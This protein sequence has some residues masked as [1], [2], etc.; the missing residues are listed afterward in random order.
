MIRSASIVLAAL[1]STSALA[2]SPG[3]T[4]GTAAVLDEGQWELGLYAALRRGMGDGLELS[5]HPLTAIKSPHLA[6]KKTWKEGE[7]WTLATRHSLLYPTPLLKTLARP[8]TG[9]ILPA[10]AEIP[11]IIAM[12][13]RFMASTGV[14]EG[15]QLTLSGRLLL[16][17]AMG[18]ANWP[19]IDMP[20]SYPRTVAYQ[21]NVAAALGVQ[22][23]GSLV[24]TLGYRVD[25]D[26][27]VLPMSEGKW[28]LEAKGTLPWRPSEHFTA[29]LSGTA[30]V[31]EYPYGTN[32]HLLPGFDLIWS[33]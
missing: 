4:H 2:T 12:D 18:T 6:A 22:V 10:D 19:T 24:G 26:A 27:W 20:L 16:A 13:T 21:D 28:A 29:Q 7:A 3:E 15:T 1:L 11:N 14:G 32:W 9:G 30:V 17:A 33:F 25:V 8:G 23:D 5:I 31:G